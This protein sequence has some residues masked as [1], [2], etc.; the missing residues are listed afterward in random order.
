[1]SSADSLFTTQPG[2]QARTEIIH[3]ETPEAM[4]QGWS[5][6]HQMYPLLGEAEYLKCLQG[7]QGHD[8]RQFAFVTE[9]N[10]C[11]G[12][13]GV[14][15]LPRIWCGLQIDI[16]N[17]VVDREARSMGV[18]KKLIDRCIEY[19]IERGASIATLD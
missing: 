19:G 1:M 6:I 2:T 3:W 17:F 7:L 13:V 9:D 8:Y 14:W 18:G 5:V 11:L 4:L 16:D 15:C 10:R 12:V